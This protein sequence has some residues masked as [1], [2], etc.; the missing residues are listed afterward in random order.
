MIAF[1]SQLVG[2]CLDWRWEHTQPHRWPTYAWL[3][4]A[5]LSPSKTQCFNNWQLP[6]KTKLP[7]FIVKKIDCSHAC[8]LYGSY[9]TCIL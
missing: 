8:I 2:Y 1:L 5:S 3:V 7:P 9:D 6:T 4:P